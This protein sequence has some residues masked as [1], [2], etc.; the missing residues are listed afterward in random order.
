MSKGLFQFLRGIWQAGILHQRQLKPLNPVL[1][2]TFNCYWENI[3]DD[4][5]AYYISEQVSHHPPKSSYFYLVPEAKI[6]V[7]GILIPKSRFWVILQLQ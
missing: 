2:E 7:D 1:G 4:C 5:S 6:K 3:S